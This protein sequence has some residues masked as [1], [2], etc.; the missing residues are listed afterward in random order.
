MDPDFPVTAAE[1]LQYVL[2]LKVAIQLTH[3]AADDRLATRDTP[4][5]AMIFLNAGSD[6]ETDVVC[7][8]Y[9]YRIRD[10][11]GGRYTIPPWAAARYQGRESFGSFDGRFNVVIHALVV[12]KSACRNLFD[13]HLRFGAR[14]L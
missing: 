7:W 1:Q 14:L 9:L 5:Q 3:A 11:H 10:A 6:K 8:R 12:S 13:E 4:S 2:R